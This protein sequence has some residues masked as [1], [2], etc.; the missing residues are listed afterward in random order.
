MQVKL[1]ADTF[2]EKVAV[3]ALLRASTKAELE[4]AKEKLREGLKVC[5]HTSSMLMRYMCYDYSSCITTAA[6]DGCIAGFEMHRH[7]DRIP[8]TFQVVEQFLQIHAV[9]AEPGYFLGDVYSWAE[10]ITTPFLRRF[11]VAIPKVRT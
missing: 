6:S 5:R 7:A 1:F 4:E 2:T 11:L 9:D 3:F 8:C 10:T